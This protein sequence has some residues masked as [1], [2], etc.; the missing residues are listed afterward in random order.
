[1]GEQFTRPCLNVHVWKAAVDKHRH[2]DIFPRRERRDEKMILEDEADGM[3]SQMANLFVVEADWVA[4][5]TCDYSL[6]NLAR[7]VGLS[8]R[9]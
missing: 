2:H 7:H 6:K 3:T 5:T 8:I 9:L 1:L 4:G